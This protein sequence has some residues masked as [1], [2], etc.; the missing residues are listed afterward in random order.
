MRST[1]ILA[2][3]LL[4][5]CSEQSLQR[6]LEGVLQSE[7][8]LSTSE[9]T[10][11]LKEALVKGA[12]DA[13]TVS[14]V[15]DGF[16]KNTSL[17]IPFPDEA[18][19]VKTTAM[20]LGLGAQ[21]TKFEET[22]NR[23]AEAAVKEATPILVNAITSMTVEDAF[24]LLKGGDTAATDYLRKKTEADLLTAFRPKV[25]QAVDNVE[26]TKY[27]N[28]LA[29]AYNTAST[30]T[31]GQVVNPDLTGYVTDRAMEGLFKL[32][33]KEEANIRANPAARGTELLRKVFGSPEATK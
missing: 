25:Q 10:S 20:N 22:L 23:A 12:Q 26:L 21:V 11:G 30:F 9:V 32:I 28:P 2:C 33:A 16:Y 15:K 8:S 27:W 6:T 24:G 1:I 3:I 29:S 13:V 4:A 7:S 17:F 19:K 18:L 31:G 5:S 14:S